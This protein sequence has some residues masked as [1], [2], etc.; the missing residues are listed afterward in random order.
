MPGRFVVCLIETPD[1]TQALNWFN[2][3]DPLLPLPLRRGQQYR[4]L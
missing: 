3:A 2:P 1:C 4:P